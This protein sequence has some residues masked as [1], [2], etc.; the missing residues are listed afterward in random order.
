MAQLRA[1]KPRTSRTSTAP[2]R[3]GQV[4]CRMPLSDLSNTREYPQPTEV[5]PNFGVEAR[6]IRLE[7]RIAQIQA[8][9]NGEALPVGTLD[10][11]LDASS[12]LDDA[13]TVELGIGLARLHKELEEFEE[14]VERT[15]ARKWLLE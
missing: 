4:Y 3:R 9:M 15:E 6:L 8:T 2:S 12:S 5:E 11:S 13:G 14:L 10:S 1:R 7:T